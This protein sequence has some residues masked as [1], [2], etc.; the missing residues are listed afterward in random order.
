MVKQLLTMLGHIFT[1]T[2]GD[3]SSDADETSV[4]ASE[5]VEGLTALYSGVLEN[6]NALN[7]AID[8]IESKSGVIMSAAIAVI[9][10]VSSVAS[11]HNSWTPY[12]AAVLVLSALIAARTISRGTYLTPAKN[13]EDGD[14]YLNMESTDLLL[15]LISD[16]QQTVKNTVGTLDSKGVLY[17]WALFTLLLGVAIC[18]APNFIP[19]LK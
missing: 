4:V 14:P 15:H 1:Q 16:A 9:T 10:L 12:G 8:G 3:V 18:A 17:K 2:F 5:N 13:L 11:F 6:V 19:I 7:S